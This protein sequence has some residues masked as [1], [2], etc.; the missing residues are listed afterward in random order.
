M[1][2]SV[3]LGP[4]DGGRVA[5]RDVTSPLSAALQEVTR[6]VVEQFD[7]ART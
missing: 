1:K 4:I 2:H 3:D 6:R 7:A 5:E